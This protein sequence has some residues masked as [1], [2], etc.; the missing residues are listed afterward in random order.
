MVEFIPAEKLKSKRRKAAWFHV[1]CNVDVSEAVNAYPAMF[2]GYL[3]KDRDMT[4]VR[5]TEKYEGQ[6]RPLTFY[7]LAIP[8]A[9]QPSG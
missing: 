6:E 3:R 8:R 2:W 7:A 9:M 1:S 5:M 4:R